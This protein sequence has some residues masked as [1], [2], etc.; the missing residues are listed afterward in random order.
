LIESL[1][2]GNR[3]S[4]TMDLGGKETKMFIE[5]SPQFKGMN[6]YDAS[7]KRLTKMNLTEMKENTQGQ[8]TKQGQKQSDDDDGGTLPSRK[9]G[10]K[11]GQRVD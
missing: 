2:R 6:L 4:V 10:R 1:E 9:K 11:R 5:A 7:M 3:Q 8:N